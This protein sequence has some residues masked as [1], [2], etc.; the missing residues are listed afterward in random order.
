MAGSAKPSVVCSPTCHS[1]RSFCSHCIPI[2]LHISRLCHCAYCTEVII[3]QAGLHN[4]DDEWCKSL[5]KLKA[6][7]SPT[8]RWW[9][10]I[11]WCTGSDALQA[12][13]MLK[14]MMPGCHRVPHKDNGTRPFS[15]GCQLFC[16]LLLGF[17]QN[18]LIGH[19]I[20]KFVSASGIMNQLWF[21]DGFCE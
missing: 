4:L 10:I 7:Y 9:A 13:E 14:R 18:A 2:T 15:R 21:G 20:H 12:V 19:L 6:L 16:K 5:E 17:S 3:N 1:S 8:W 11:Q